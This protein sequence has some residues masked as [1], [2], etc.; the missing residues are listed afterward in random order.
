MIA[1]PGRAILF[2]PGAPFAFFANEW[3]FRQVECLP[4]SKSIDASVN[5]GKPT[6]RKVR[7]VWGTRNPALGTPGG[8]LFDR[9]QI[10]VEP[11]EGFLDL[12]IPGNVV[13]GVVEDTS[14]ILFGRSQ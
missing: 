7:E 12:L 13:A 10:A 14:L 11:V 2:L 1:R 9:P 5:V 6:H 8:C 4:S 3:I